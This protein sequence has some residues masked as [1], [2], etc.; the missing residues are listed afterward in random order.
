VREESIDADGAPDR[1]TEAVDATASAYTQDAGLD[2]RQ[3]LVDE[4][5]RR[6]ISHDGA[7]W[8]DELVDAVRAGHS[9][10]LTSGPERQF[11]IS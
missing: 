9:G 1:V 7:A 4:L 8:V 11:P 3:R 10:D 5:E 6:G 2:V